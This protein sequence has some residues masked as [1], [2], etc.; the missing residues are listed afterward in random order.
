MLIE[1]FGD[2]RADGHARIETRL[3]IWNII[4]IRGRIRRSSDV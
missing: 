2:D 3:R 4:C 1:R